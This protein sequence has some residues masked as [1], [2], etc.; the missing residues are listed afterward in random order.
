M[1]NQEFA[2]TDSDFKAACNLAGTAATSRQASKWRMGRGIAY[3]T[4]EISK[5][6]TQSAK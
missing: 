1:T 3:K 4:W 5:P 2:K 6:S